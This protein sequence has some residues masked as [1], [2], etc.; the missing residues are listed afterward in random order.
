MHTLLSGLA[1]LPKNSR[2]LNVVGSLNVNAHY[3]RAVRRQIELAGLVQ[4]AL[5]G[6]VSDE[7]LSEY[8][9]QS[10]VLAVP[11]SHEGFGIVYLEG[12]R[13]GL[14]SIASSDG[15]A[16]ELIAHG[17]EGFLVAPGDIEAITHHLNELNEN[18]ETLIQMSLA[19]RR[20][21]AAHPTWAESSE[22][23]REFLVKA[24]D[25]KL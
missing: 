7:R 17:Q 21:H 1:R 16:R 10:H 3:V 15:G 9:A 22:S 20:R 24:L 14:P 18:R 2:S 13:F 19:A 8:Y 25:E 4:V 5:L 23:I 6:A 12:M 11:S